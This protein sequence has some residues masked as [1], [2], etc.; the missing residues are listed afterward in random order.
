MT[1]EFAGDLWMEQQTDGR[2]RLGFRKHFIDA[3]CGE[4]F[5]IMQA[6]V[7]QVKKGGPLFVLESNDGLTPVKSPLA[8]KILYFNTKARNFPDRL[9]EE[10]VLLEIL[11]EG[12]K[13]KQE[14][15]SKAT[16]VKEDYV[17]WGDPFQIQ[18]FANPQEIIAQERQ[19][20]NEALERTRAQEAM[21]QRAFQV[22]NARAG[23]PVPP[24]N[25]AIPRIAGGARAA[26]SRA[27]RRPR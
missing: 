21:I 7:Q 25:G 3:R 17:Q 13:L 1:K 8:G 4:C 20:Q 19:R 18:G 6:D 24:P 15:K 16:K 10:D 23:D 14:E 27:V 11:P 26:P 2:V 22:R 9:I 12:V 5:H